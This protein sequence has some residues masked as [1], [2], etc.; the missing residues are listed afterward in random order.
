M[1]VLASV[2]CAVAPTVAVLV[3][4]RVLQTYAGLLRDRTFVGMILV[5]GLTM[6][7]LYAY[8]AAA[9]FVFQDRFGLDP[10][11]LG[12]LLGASSILF[13]GA[14]QLN[15]L[16]LDRHQPQHILLA[17]A[18]TGSAA[19]AALCLTA[20]TAT[21]GLLGVLPPL[22]VVMFALGLMLP[23]APVLALADH[24]DAA[25]TAAALVGAAQFGT[26]AVAA[27]LVGLLGNDTLAMATVITAAHAGHHH[28]DPD[29]QGTAPTP[30]EG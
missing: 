6:A 10:Q 15:P 11:Q 9:P 26:A 4:A 30:K 2:G 1:H 14:T 13:V 8:L 29:H 19:G 12:L 28:P 16:L 7:A 27:P 22:S 20:A 24:G 17:A 25:G 23:N 18:V 5:V 21:G 3:A